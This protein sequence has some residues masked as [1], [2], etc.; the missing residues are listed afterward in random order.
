MSSNMSD[1]E[2][3]CLATKRVKPRSL[4]CTCFASYPHC[5]CAI[6]ECAIALNMVGCSN[7]ENTPPCFVCR[8]G[9]CG[10]RVL[11]HRLGVL[12]LSRATGTWARKEIEKRTPDAQ[13][14]QTPIGLLATA[15]P[16]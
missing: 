9:G 7:P 11:F 6:A 1:Q 10:I 16:G 13:Q 15:E 5:E 14:K 8:L 3:R 12:A 4:P 2:L